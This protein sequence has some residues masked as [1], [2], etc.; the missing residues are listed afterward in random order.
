MNIKFIQ[1][2]YMHLFRCKTCAWKFVYLIGCCMM[3]MVSLAQS[4]PDTTMQIWR[5]TE[6]HKHKVSLTAFL[7]QNQNPVTSVIICSGGS[8]CWLAKQTE[9]EDV[10]KW[11]QSNGI[12]AFVLHYRV[13][14][15]WSYFSHDRIL[16]R[17]HQF[18]DMIEDIQRAIQ[19]VRENADIYGINPNQIG[20]MGFSAGGH[21]SIMAGTF[22][23]T[24][25]LAPHRIQTNVS[26]RPD[27]IAP[28][29]PVVTMSGKYAHRR[30]RRGALGEY[31]KGK[32]IW[33]DSLS[34]EKHVHSHMPP[35]FLMNCVDDPT[36]KY[37][38]SELLDS[39]LTANN[40]S[41]RYIQYQTGGHGFGATPKKTTDEAIS[42]KQE[43]L[44]WIKDIFNK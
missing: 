14:G 28:I 26:L 21:L 42:W 30:S 12:A 23:E 10:A 13:A 16:F 43:F 4:L 38:N 41:H 44:Y 17:K 25:F 31:K 8:Y 33:R 22:F 18:P 32:N 36:V 20:V 15:F 37:Q 1:K 27:F 9:G 2:L 35:V 19:I 3:P 24:D 34:M 7:P 29:Y 40:I 6:L 5:D 39:A 11:L